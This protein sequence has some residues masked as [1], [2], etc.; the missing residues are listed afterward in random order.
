MVGRRCAQIDRRI[1]HCKQR[2][3]DVVEVRTREQFQYV[4]VDGQRK[5]VKPQ[6]VRPAHWKGEFTGY[7]LIERH[8]VAYGKWGATGMIPAY[9]WADI[10]HDCF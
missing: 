3:Y 7:V 4:L 6:H 2:L 5:P 9:H 8:Y 10:C 1:R